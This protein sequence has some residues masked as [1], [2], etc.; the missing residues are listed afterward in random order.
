L[1]GGSATP[2]SPGTQV[3]AADE[4]DGSTQQ[5]LAVPAGSANFPSSARVLVNVRTG[6]CLTVPGSSKAENTRLDQERCAPNYDDPSQLWDARR[7]AD[8]SYVLANVSSGLVLSVA[9]A[10]AAEGP[11]K[12]GG[13]AARERPDQERSGEPQAAAGPS[14]TR[15]GR[16]TSQIL[17]LSATRTTTP[18]ISFRR[19]GPIFIRT[20]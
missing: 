15:P 13:R 12:P 3:A 17:R 9:A 18:A 7:Q 16:R 14:G 19:D 20:W 10:S 2:G 5:W 1:A 4:R 11:A 6:L 8:G